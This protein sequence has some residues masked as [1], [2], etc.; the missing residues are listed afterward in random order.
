MSSYFIPQWPHRESTSTSPYY[1]W[2]NCSTEKMNSLREMGV[3]WGWHGLGVMQVRVHSSSSFLTPA[4]WPCDST[5]LSLSFLLCQMGN[6]LGPLKDLRHGRSERGPSFPEAV[7]SVTSLLQFKVHSGLVTSE[8]EDG[9]LVREEL[10]SHLL[11]IAPDSVGLR[12]PRDMKYQCHFGNS[13]PT[14]QGA[15]DR[16]HQLCRCWQRGW[17]L[18]TRPDSQDTRSF[19]ITF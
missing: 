8:G 9:S 16:Q 11:G 17:A 3:E 18:Q 5:C 6:G 13:N 1:R 19:L 10:L 2:G 15:L 7:V 14:Q 4:A 12:K